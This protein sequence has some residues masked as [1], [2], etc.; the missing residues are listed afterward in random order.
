V[1]YARFIPHA[2]EGELMAEKIEKALVVTPDQ[3]DAKYNEAVTKP[4]A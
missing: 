1:H 2:S 3:K 4:S